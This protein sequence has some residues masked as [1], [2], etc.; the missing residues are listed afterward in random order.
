MIYLRYK[1]FKT[2]VEVEVI[3]KKYDSRRKKKP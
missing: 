3:E 1:N 2:E